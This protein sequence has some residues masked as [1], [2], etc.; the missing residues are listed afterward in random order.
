GDD[1]D[2]ACGAHRRAA[3]ACDAAHRAVL[4]VHQ[5]VHAA[6]AL[7][8]VGLR[9]GAVAVAD[10]VDVAH[11]LRHRVLEEVP[12]GR[13]QALEDRGQVDLI[14]CG[15][16]QRDLLDP[17]RHGFAP[18]AGDCGCA[19]CGCSC[20]CCAGGCCCA[21]CC[22]CAGGCSSGLPVIA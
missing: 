3:H 15:P 8:G 4:A 18:R 20:C 2:A 12:R 19:C 11:P 13:E 5:A 7:G 10:G 6:E 1:V 21:G 16:L 9:V 22:C 17:D 14:A